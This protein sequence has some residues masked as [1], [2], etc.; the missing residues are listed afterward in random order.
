MRE[1]VAGVFEGD[2]GGASRCALN[3]IVGYNTE[4]A[5]DVSGGYFGGVP[6]KGYFE[7]NLN[8][9]LKSLFLQG[10]VPYESITTHENDAIQSSLLLSSAKGKDLPR[11]QLRYTK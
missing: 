11:T 7:R 10:I 9:H 5:F 4:V 8:P 1:G 3:G 6:F 2:L